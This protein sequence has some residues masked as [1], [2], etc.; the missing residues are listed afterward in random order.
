M[1]PL[2]LGSNIGTTLTGFIAAMVSANVNS[3]QVALAHL[4]FNLTGILIFYPIPCK[5]SSQSASYLLFIMNLTVTGL[6]LFTVMRRI[7]L[8]LA[9][10]LGLATRVW[11]FFPIVYIGFAFFAAPLILLAISTLFTQDSVGMTA[12]GSII[13]TFLL[14]GIFYFIFWWRWK[15]GRIKCYNY[16]V[17]RQ[18][19]SEMMKALPETIDQI[20][21]DVTRIKEV[22]GVPEDC[23]KENEEAEKLLS[24]HI[25]DITD[26]FAEVEG[27]N[28]S[29]GGKSI[30]D[31]LAFEESFKV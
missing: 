9:R 18:K 20:Q 29:G 3:L 23:K 21:S 31:E 12:L 7:P 2:T 27:K 15:L 30:M 13:V 24:E 5:F 1:Y 14:L 17:G 25:T 16:F 28:E 6:L 4:F 26:D 10:Q 22:I 8:H 19:R 11:K